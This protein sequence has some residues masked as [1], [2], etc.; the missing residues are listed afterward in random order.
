MN[1]EE[2]K[3]SE[4]ILWWR[5]ELSALQGRCYEDINHEWMPDGA[6]LEMTQAGDAIG[7]ALSE[8]AKQSET[9]TKQ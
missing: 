1:S 6:G 2:I 4:H 5:D 8:L 7:R 3:I 9:K